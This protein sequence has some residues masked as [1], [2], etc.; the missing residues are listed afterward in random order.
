MQEQ[1][2]APR[3]LEAVQRVRLR[4]LAGAAHALLLGGHDAGEQLL[5]RLHRVP[6]MCV[7]RVGGNVWRCGM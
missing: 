1:R 4:R 7:E 3:A 2:Q 5:L 6:G